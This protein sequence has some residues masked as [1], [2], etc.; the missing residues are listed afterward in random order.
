MKQAKSQ[1]KPAR[2]IFSRGM[3]GLAGLAL[4]WA[5]AQSAAGETAGEAAGKAAGAAANL[6]GSLPAATDYAARMEQLSRFLIWVSAAACILVTA[7]FVYFALRY[8]RRSKEER[9]RA[10]TLHNTPLE[11]LWSFIPFVIFM[12]AFVWGWIVYDELQR[13]P[14]DSIE[15]H[16]SGQ[17]WSWSFVYKSGRK[18]SNELYVPLDRP[19]KLIMTSRDVLHSFF[20]PAFRIKQDVVPGMYT[21]LWFKA[22]RLGSFHVFCAELCGAGHSDMLA[23][24]HVLPLED[25]EEWMRN[26][27]SRGLSLPQIGEKIFQSRCAVCHKTKIGPELAGVFGSKRKIQGG[28]SVTAD[29]N[30]LRESILNP[31]AKISEGF[32]NQMT[33]FAGLLTEEELSG[34]I[35][36]IKELK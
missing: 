13:P 23:K 10:E 12:T 9:G 19:V 8:K 1:K 25:W 21:S 4:F 30:Y 22:R 29:E 17:M 11:F 16:V 28:G 36:Y 7:A 34:V 27:P 18:T 14:E 6:A 15:I 35:E 32:Q 3:P 24:V 33:P 20:I 31:S 26:D 2:L 5:S